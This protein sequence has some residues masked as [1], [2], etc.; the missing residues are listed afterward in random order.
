M[1][2]RF[3]I[4]SRLYL[5]AG[6]LSAVMLLVGLFGIRELGQAHNALKSVYEDNTVAL[7]HISTVEAENLRIRLN[8]ATLLLKP[9]REVIDEILSKNADHVEI[10]TKELKLYSETPMTSQ[11]QEIANATAHDIDTYNSKGITPLESLIRIGKIED[12]K[13]FYMA[14]FISMYSVVTADMKKISSMQIE[15]A[16]SKYDT[17]SADYKLTKIIF[18][19]LILG[20]LAI[21]FAVAW[22]IINGIARSLTAVKEVTEAAAKG[23]LTRDVPVISK[24]EIGDVAE[25][26]NTMIKNVKRVIGSINTSTATL[27]SSSEELSAT[28]EELSK[29]TSDLSA[30]TDQVVTAM[31]EVSQTIVDMAKNA[32]NAADAA[33]RSVETADAGKENIDL[34]TDGMVNIAATVNES[35][36]MIEMLGKNSA[37]IGEIVIV[38][39]SIAE[40]TNLLALNAAIE[41]ARAGEQG[42][43]FAVVADE[44]RKLAERTGQATRDI[45]KRIE[46]I[47][48]DT[49]KSVAAVKKGAEEV[50]KGK[51]LV[52][53]AKEA[54][55]SIVVVSG[56]ST[57]MVQRIAAATEEQSAATDQVSRSMESIADF[58]RRTAASTEQ[59]KSSAG[60]LSRLALNL[61]EN[62]AWFKV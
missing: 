38:I 3:K 28:S 17:F 32:T 21:G 35:A 9:T 13:A 52:S 43:G 49:K 29:G 39:N 19:V 47:Q 34:A 2:N 27:A 22:G 36:E 1:F 14:D 30:Q 4:K 7:S 57:D 20:G 18:V 54:L 37:Q 56:K 55:S 23:D 11:E 46:A 31:T 25:S 59:I 50:A 16:K 45:S 48:D 61:R 12:A 10:I 62:V 41:A 26:F 5:L 60:N 33:A 42:R 40:Q 6:T 58:S 15:E 44:V 8:L 53:S 51:G 24:D